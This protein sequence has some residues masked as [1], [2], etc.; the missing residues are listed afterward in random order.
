MSLAELEGGKTE[1]A[2]RL[3]PIHPLLIRLGLL[4]WRDLMLA[5]QSERLFPQWRPPLD[6]HGDPRWADPVTKLW[7]TVRKHAQLT[8]Q[9]VSAYSLRHQFADWL[10]RAVS[11]QRTRNRVVGHVDKLNEADTFGSKSYMSP[12]VAMQITGLDNPVIRQIA[13][14]LNAAKDKAD[15]GELKT[16]RPGVDASR[17]SLVP[18]LKNDPRSKRSH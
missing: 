9:N 12:E 4:E 3:I 11:N 5:Q 16:L 8:E 7:R 18:R 6:K 17:S 1:N 13:A 2:A 14:V 10:D 15:R